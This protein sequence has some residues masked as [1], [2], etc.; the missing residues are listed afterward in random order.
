MLDAKLDAGAS[1]DVVFCGGKDGGVQGSLVHRFNESQSAVKASYVEL[2]PDTDA[3][4]TAAIQRLEGG[5]ADCDVY[6]TD[7]TWTPEWASQGWLYDQTDLVKAAAGN[8]M[9][10]IIATTAYDGRNWG[11]PF[12]TNAGLMF[13]RTDRVTTPKTWKD[14]YAQAASSP[15][16]KLLMQ[17][18]SYEGL[19]VNFLEVLYSAG[20]EVINEK[21]EVVIDNETTREVLTFMRDGFVNGS[22]DPASLTYDEGAG[23]RAFES[24]VGGFQRNWPNAFKS[25]HDAGLG[26]VTGVTPL[27]AFD[28]G[29]EPAAVL[30]GW[31]L[32]VPT[33]AK[34]PGGAVA[35]I[36]F[37]VSDANQKEQFLISSQAPVVASVYSDPE[38]VAKFPFAAELHSSLQSAKPR[39]KSP[40]YAQISRAIYEN[41]YAVINGGANADVDAAV[42]K[43][44]AEIEKAQGTF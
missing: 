19:T 29:D 42:K 17:A 33:T 18:K 26:D 4:R 36:K 44:A 35:F 38:V 15:D 30:G 31:N 8:V 3:A 6:M 5:S 23:R 27:P 21:G 9:D 22:V 37:T 10:S 14:L 43:M 12:Y 13:Y 2:G 25:A 24:G 40:V 39:P 1:G 20:G 11:T 7:V 28:E 34:N 32:A 41:V 16:N